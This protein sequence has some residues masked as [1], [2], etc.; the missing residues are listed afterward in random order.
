MNLLN[1][2]LKKIYL[3]YLYAS[4]GSALVASI[5]GVVD[6]VMVGQYHGPEGSAA[7]AVISPIWNIL[8]SFGLLTG[9]G[10]SVLLSNSKGKGE[11]RSKQNEYFTMSFILTIVF[12]ILLWVSLNI[13]EEPLLRLFGANETLMPL[14]KQYLLPVRFTVPIFLFTQMLAAFLRNDNDPS[15]ATK[16]VMMG[17]LINVFGDYFLVFTCKLGI[18]GAAVATVGSASVSII[19][20]STHFRSQNNTLRL[21]RPT[22]ILNKV[23][24]IITMGFSTFFIDIAMG[25]L[26]MLFNRQIMTYLGTN[27]LAVYGIIV[28]ISTFVQC[29]G[30]GIGQAS[31][32]LL[33]IN[34]GA[35]ETKRVSQ[36]VK[37]NLVTVAIVSVVWVLIVTSI[38]TGL[39]KLFMTPNDEV[40][41]I[42]PEI[43]RVYGLSFFL[44]PFNV[45][46]TYYFQSTLQP[47]VSFMVSLLRGALL[48]GGLIL[49]LPVSFGGS[50]IWWAMPL[51]E[52]LTSVYVVIMMNKTRKNTLRLSTFAD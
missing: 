24:R 14:A 33:T 22:F 11:S 17:G 49:L 5:Y 20:M 45:Y 31:Q 4:F 10:G 3:K 26:T 32:P 21:V 12:S 29:C 48:S 39:V 23:K 15:L 7:M 44:L 2:N 47:F 16:A 8:Y 28:N 51:S 1:G 30:Y 36:L 41:R 52:L 42:A 6:M 13:F 34:Y 50:A 18:L 40:L 35:K 43:I 19:V 27:A 37:Y 38:P 46:A 25:F 9:I